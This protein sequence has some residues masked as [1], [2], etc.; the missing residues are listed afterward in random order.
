MSAVSA[1]AA[2]KRPLGASL[3]L[4][5]GFGCPIQTLLVLVVDHVV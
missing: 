4:T 5:K 2:P 1:R 3:H